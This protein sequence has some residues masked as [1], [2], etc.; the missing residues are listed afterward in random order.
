MVL[1]VEEREGNGGDVHDLPVPQS[2]PVDALPDGDSWLQ[3]DQTL[4]HHACGHVGFVC[5]VCEVRR[6]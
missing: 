2:I 5:P 1:A 4:P 3:A 6:H